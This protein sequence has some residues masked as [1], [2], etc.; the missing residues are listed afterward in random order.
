MIETKELTK[1]FSGRLAVNHVSLTV[2]DGQI[3]GLLGTNGAGKS[4]TIRMMTGVLKPDE[5]QVLIDEKPVYQNPAVKQDLIFLSD[6]LY[7]FQG[8]TPLSMMRYYSS[9][10][11]DFDKNGFLTNLE[12]FEL[13]QNRRLQTFSKGMKKQLVMLLGLHANTRYLFCD[14]TFD[15]L[16]PVMRQSFKK[17]IAYAKSQRKLTCVIASHNLRELEDTCDRVGLLHKGG[18]LM[19]EDLT[20]LKTNVHKMQVV[21]KSETDALV[22]MQNLNVISCE[23]RGSLYTLTVRGKREALLAHFS[24]VGTVFFELLPLTLEE[25]FISE[26]EVAGYDIAKLFAG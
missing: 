5:G 11:P 12:L 22:G 24:N 8:A 9:L 10:Y 21:F 15:G 3:F 6:E 2:N 13:G 23:Q 17:M 18:I 4:T 19:A 20:E 7:F 25:I 14:E 26:T 1:A 16:D